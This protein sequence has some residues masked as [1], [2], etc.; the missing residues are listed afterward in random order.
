MRSGSMCAGVL[1]RLWE[2]D[3]GANAAEAA[4]TGGGTEIGSGGVAGHVEQR[5]GAHRENVAH[6]CD[7]G[8]VDFQ[9]LVERH[10]AL[11]G[12]R[13]TGSGYEGLGCRG[14]WQ[15]A[16][17]LGTAFDHRR[18][19]NIWYMSVTLAVSKLSGWL[20]DVASCRVREE[21]SSGGVLNC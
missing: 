10:R 14:V 4:C 5:G 13:K 17:H 11:H 6:V 12:Q 8:R 20:K 9:R 18:T 15:A 2:A 3:V 19:V 21:G 16:A 7:A 1:G